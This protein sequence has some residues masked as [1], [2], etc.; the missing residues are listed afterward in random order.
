VIDLGL[1]D[2]DYAEYLRALRSS[3][4]MGVTIKIRNRQEELL[5]A[6]EVPAGRLIGGSVQVDKGAE[7]TRSLGLEFL[8]PE[9]AL[10]FDITAPG[11][12]MFVDRFVSVSR[13]V[14]V[15]AL[16]RW[17]RCPVFWG[18]LSAMNRS[19]P[20]I[21]LEAQGKESLLLAPGYA[22]EGYMLAKGAA[23][24]AA[25][26]RVARRAGERRLAVG[27][28][29]RG[30][31]RARAVRSRSEPWKVIVGGEDTTQG[32]R[33]PG[34]IENLEGEHVVF[35]D[36]RGRLTVRRAIR[37]PVFTFT[38]A[39]LLGQP[40]FAYD[41]TEFRNAIDVRG[42]KPEGKKKA[43]HARVALPAN[44]AHAPA[45]LGRNNRKRWLIDFEDATNA[46]TDADC[47]ER[48]R[49]ILDK[50]SRQALEAS[51]ECLP[52]PHLEEVD[53][54]RLRSED[55]TVEFPLRTFTIPLT[56]DTP[57]SVGYNRRRRLRRHR[58]RGGWPRHR[59]ARSVRR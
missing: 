37:K 17:V 46:K 54:V 5:E 23:T 16:G 6:L 30:L 35:Y 57:M 48:A 25:I 15:E 2:D 39:Y 55:F 18:P 47:R 13:D 56:P 45:R 26:R 52:V 58:R 11:A 49:A 19:G 22:T 32:R 9:H 44:N 31:R 12:G 29:P 42:E 10:R 21:T 27:V 43:P 38:D 51:F 28:Y 41:M 34:I 33:I 8:D 36:G 24:G 59:R 50:R 53:M 1:S 14:Y 3:H 40:A 20:V 4:R 7:V